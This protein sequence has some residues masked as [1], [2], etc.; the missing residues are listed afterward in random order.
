MSLLTDLSNDAASLAEQVAPRIVAVRGANGR[1]SSGFVWRT[2]L[3]VT[4]EEA[5]EGEDDAEVLLA[6][7]KVVKATLAGR[8]PSTDVALLK[9]DT[10]EF[11]EWSAAGTP[12]PASFALIAGRAEGSLIASLTSVNEAGP[13]WRSLRGGQ[14]DA[15]ITL[16][17]R[18]GSRT[19]GGAVVAPD[20][21]LIGMAV[22]SPQRRAL[23]I[24]AST[25]GRAVVTLNEKG[26]VPRGWLG[27]MLH[28]VGTGAGAIVLGL[29][30]ESPGGKAGL[31]VGDV[32]TT[33]DG[34]VVSSVGNIA[35]RL[36]GSA[37][38]SKVNLG[39]S[40]GGNAHNVEV[41][42]GERPRG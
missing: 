3:V 24:P 25:I 38:G 34:D 6:D 10:A 39:V 30:D 7:G 16:A 17:L 19:E 37:V 2:G 12:R 13:A 29:E 36:V 22:T 40:R 26:Y 27:V 33:W 20:G 42:L 18:L 11:G 28:P 15:R 23:V 5:L 8:D 41:T 31:L 21:T 35:Q 1:S 9:L 32:I 4:A 14:I